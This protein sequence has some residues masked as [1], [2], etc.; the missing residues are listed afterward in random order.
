MEMSKSALAKVK[1]MYMN[2]HLRLSM[3]QSVKQK[4]QTIRTPKVKK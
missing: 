3:N 4:V 2:N 1:F